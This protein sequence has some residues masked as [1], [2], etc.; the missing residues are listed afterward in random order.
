MQ[1]CI[2][3]NGG[4]VSLAK[5]IEGIYDRSWIIEYSNYDLL[6]EYFKKAAA[7]GRYMFIVKVEHLSSVE[8]QELM[9]KLTNDEFY[10][11]NYNG[12]EHILEVTFN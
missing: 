8:K 9:D 10:I 11:S 1:E 3:Y 6:S 7:F 2:G 4:I 5:E 12:N